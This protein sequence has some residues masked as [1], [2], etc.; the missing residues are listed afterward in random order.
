MRRKT[1]LERFPDAR[2]VCQQSGEVLR[3][4]K[5]IQINFRDESE[6]FA[7]QVGNQTRRV[8]IGNWMTGDGCVGVAVTAGLSILMMRTLITI[9]LVICDIHC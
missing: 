8:R 6:S 1:Q 2:M 3:G 7:C 4:N 5:F 9:V